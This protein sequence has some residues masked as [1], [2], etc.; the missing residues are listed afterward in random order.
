MFVLGTAGH[1]DHG[2]STLVT[3]LT[4]IDPDRLPEEKARGMTIDLGFAW[5]A[6]P[7]GLEVG[8]VDVPG[9]ERFVR[10]M[11]AGV[12]GID[13][14]L[15]VVAADDGWMPQSAEHLAILK[16]L[17]IQRGLIVL[18]KIDLVKPDWRILVEE[19]IREKL[20]GSFLA[21]APLVKVSAPTGEGVETLKQEIGS[22]VAR[23]APRRDLGKPRLFI[24][25]VFS[26]AGRGTVVTGTLRDGSLRVGE[27]IEILPTGLRA[28]IRG[29]ET[30]KKPVEQSG[31]GA[32][33]ALNLSGVDKEKLSRG[34]LII[35]P[36][37]GFLTR[38][39][40]ASVA[41]WEQS[42]FPLKDNSEVLFLLGTSE[43]RA[44]VHL[45]DRSV[46]QPGEEVLV[47]FTAPSPVA[48]RIGDHFILRL[49]SPGVTLAGGKVLELEPFWRKR[50]TPEVRAYLSER[51]SLAASDLLRSELEKSVVQPRTTLLFH[52][53]I[54]PAEIEAALLDLER[55][56][57]LWQWGGFVGLRQKI[58]GLQREIVTLV[59]KE[60]QT[61]PYRLGIV[62][63]EM[64][65][66]LRKNEAEIDP[67]IVQML[68]K[69]LLVQEAGF[70]RL[71]PFSPRLLPEQ[72]RQVEKLLNEFE[73]SPY[74]APTKEEIFARGDGWKDLVAFLLYQKT[75]IDC[76]DG[77]LLRALDWEA[78]TRKVTAFFKENGTMTVGQLRDL[79]HTSRKYAVPILE[80]L[81][82][83]GLTRRVGDQRVL[84]DTH[85]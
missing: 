41:L 21:Q 37:Q 39:W 15:F 22:L 9:H 6:L 23:L 64:A 84:V 80:K 3:R 35:K 38:R 28:R 78:V 29:L 57:L 68:E 73:Q 30:H 49:P 79:L 10:N 83:V 63:A 76:G 67:L 55:Q 12:G 51:V 2:K 19:D 82:H 65:G 53:H 61:H 71:P 50:R 43:T 74:G 1:V 32:R 42:P 44:K 77:V 27:E 59:E 56:Q 81:D 52:S 36:G 24:D 34:D 14:V 5:L 13:A 8:I 47:E 72:E 60:H 26:M 33:L 25:R 48:A 16:L 62:R 45:L 31:P 75:L 7:S 69:G 46:A 66:R 58:E 11:I 20:K 17:G 18:T 70:L 54:A 4:G 40:A 85:D